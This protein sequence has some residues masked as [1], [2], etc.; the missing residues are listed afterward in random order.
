[1]TDMLSIAQSGVRAYARALDVVAD[2]VANAATPG[3]V[4]R[5]STLAPATLGGS[6]GRLDL[7]P[8]GGT[9]V[10][11]T[12][13]ARAVDLL[14]ADTLRRAEGDVA[15]LAA[16]DRWLSGVQS[17][18]SGANA[19]EIPLNELFSSLADL[20]DDPAS[21]PVRQAFLARVETLA[22]RFNRNAADLRTLDADIQA[23]ADVELRTLN[24][25]ARGVAD[26]NA[27][28]RRATAGS[29]ASVVLADERDRL[30]G[31]LS[32]LVQFDV[33]FDARGQA[34]VRIPDAGGPALVA[35]DRVEPARLRAE[36]GGLALRLGP[37][38]NDEGAALTGGSLLGLATARRLLGQA[39]ARLDS[40]AARVA[41]AFN[42]AHQAGIDA[43]GQDGLPLFETR[44]PLV[45]PARANGGDARVSAGLAAG[46]EPP[47]LTLSFDGSG[48]TLA[49]DD[50]SDSVS[51][52]L[53][54]TLD[55]LT[56][57]AEGAARPGDIFRLRAV[58]GAA[59]IAARA[60]GPDE[61]AAAPRFQADAAPS[62]AGAAR[63]SL[64]LSAPLGSAGPPFTLVVLAGG[65]IELRDS[66]DALL[67]TGAA[68]EW[69][70]GD[71][72]EARLDGRAAEGDRFRIERTG[73]RDGANGNALA[74]LA[75][76]DADGPGGTLGEVQDSMVSGIAVPLAE[77]RTRA[78]IARGN[79]NS[80]AEALQERSGVD[81]NTEAA[82][83]LRLQQ[84]FQ[85]NAR[86][87]QTARETFDAILA[88]T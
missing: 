68:G 16:A 70:T 21:P 56:A 10:R 9:G 59:G 15:A 13:I 50:G 85:A 8:A 83:M 76:R 35:G 61:V 39:E 12:G 84:A 23:E 48:W 60:L 11:L 33:Q 57:D 46:A 45:L 86:L 81:L 1:M 34:T 6:Q 79:R 88:A 74:M 75:L 51:G 64:R 43:A 17:A 65:G 69:L 77:T 47:P 42:G 52:P 53:P 25:L 78:E 55:G 4:R 24:S 62:N 71:G 66:A 20:A 41:A 80:A 28:L 87:I 29:G 5:L 82:E 27:Q 30:L 7:D 54:L 40:L 63:V 49:R 26:L 31:Q 44:R 72:F 3:H 36:G 32:T 37:S 58:E 73:A 18:L 19:V 67:G 22:D 38:G 14:R 2:N